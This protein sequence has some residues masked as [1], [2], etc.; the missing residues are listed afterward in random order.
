MSRRPG[1][2]VGRLPAILHGLHRLAATIGETRYDLAIPVQRKSHVAS[3]TLVTPLARILREPL[4]HFAVFAVILFVVYAILNDDAPPPPSQDAILISQDD[5]RALAQQFAGV[6]NRQPVQEELDT[7]IASYVDE[8]V[9]VRE[10]LK[11]GLDRNDPVIRNRLRQKM[12]F[13]AE[14]ESQ[15]LVPDDTVLEQHLQANPE[16]FSNPGQITFQQVYLGETPSQEAVRQSS[17]LL[18]DGQDPAQVG[19]NTLLPVAMEAALPQQVDRLF[20]TGFFESMA[21]VADTEWAG[22]IRSGY[23]LHLVRITDR[24]APLQ[25][26]LSEVRDDVLA[27]WRREQSQILADAYLAALRDTYDIALPDTTQLQDIVTQ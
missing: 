20:G 10:A 8:E 14:S 3:L 17:A 22:P 15:T 27:D 1:S 16:R 19:A 7:L 24:V 13:L 4:L 11:L 6:W 5:A 25:P 9:L 23:G 26:S 18:A 12:M 2:G 21:Q